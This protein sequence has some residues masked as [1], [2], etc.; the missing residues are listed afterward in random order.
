VRLTSRGR[1]TT[2]Q[3]G[4]AA[5]AARAGGEGETTLSAGLNT[6]FV[7]LSSLERMPE[8]KCDLVPSLGTGC[9]YHNS[10]DVARRIVNLVRISSHACIANVLIDAG[11]FS[12]PSGKDPHCAVSAFARRYQE[13]KLSC[14]G[15][16]FTMRAARCAVIVSV[17]CVTWIAR[18]AGAQPGADS[19]ETVSDLVDRYITGSMARQHIPGL[20]LVVIRDGEIVK[21]KGYGLASLELHVPAKPETVYELASATKP[22]VAAAF[23]G[24][25]SKRWPRLLH[26]PGETSLTGRCRNSAGS[27]ASHSFGR[28][29]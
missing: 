23:G 1:A 24:S 26:R 27:R 9:S 14:E 13:F 25:R 5:A 15:I 11:T 21:A 2:R 18:T 6:D 22:F 29:M 12:R 3:E 19:G 16:V 10:R 4:R 28:K 17:A 20:S 7:D 8:E